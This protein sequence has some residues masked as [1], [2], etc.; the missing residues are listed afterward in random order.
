M[1]KRLWIPLAL[2]VSIA[3]G[4]LGDSPVPREVLTAGPYRVLS[5]DFHLHSGLGSGGSL[6]PWGLVTEAQ[7]QGLDVIALTGH[8]ETWDA[9]VAHA[10]ARLI[11]GPIVLVGEEVTSKAQDLVAV[12]IRD[13]IPPGLP[14]VAQIADV[15]R[16]GGVAIAA[17]PRA[18]FYAIYRDTGAIALIDGTE[19]C[20]PMIYG[21]AG[22]ADEIAAFAA[23]T[24]AAPIGSSDFHWSGRIGACRTFLFVDEPTE[25]GVLAAIRAH[26]TVVYGFNGR[27]FGDPALIRLAD[28]A[29]L[30]EVAAGYTRVRGGGLDWMS[31]I[32][33]AIA[34]FGIALVT[35]A[36]ASRPAAERHE[37]GPRAP[38]R[39]P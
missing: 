17:H 38:A 33:A 25:R 31:R 30:P 18:R 39:C 23:A 20:H 9:H 21:L 26:R 16:Q 22:N 1:I 35:K 32:T 11:D 6:T 4:T 13:T 19:V 3:A 36:R 2:F 24:T 10:F 14:L 34:L 15:H 27:A 28:A 37:S 29:G 7:R 8:N 12:G 5:G